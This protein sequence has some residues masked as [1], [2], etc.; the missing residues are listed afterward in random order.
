MSGFLDDCWRGAPHWFLL[1]AVLSHL[2]ARRISSP[3]KALAWAL[4]LS[5]LA[6][7]PLAPH[8]IGILHGALGTLSMGSI[9]LAALLITNLWHE[10]KSAPRPGV[11]ESCGLIALIGIALYGNYLGF[12][13]LPG[14]GLYAQGFASLW[15][16]F[17]IGAWGVYSAWRGWLWPALWVM[18]ALLAWILSWSAS[19]N[20]WDYL[21]DAPLWLFSIFYGIRIL[22]VRIRTRRATS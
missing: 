21:I 6:W 10:D 16:P 14:S 4:L 17:A 11:R 20:L 18:I 22:V 12:I 13:P 2:L 15:L 8:L 1:V 19:M 7:L 9:V 3:P 5:I